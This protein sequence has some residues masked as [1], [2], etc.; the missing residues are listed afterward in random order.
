MAAFERIL[1][2]IP[3][4]DEAFH[5]IRLGDNVVWQVSDL[6]E[7]RAFV[8]PY[9]EQAKRDKRNLIYI[10]FAAHE[11]II[12]D[13]EGVKVYQVKLSHRFETFTIEIHRI[14]EK[15]GR[16]A[17]Y[18]FDC[19]SELQVAWSTDLM[20][21]N[22]FRVTCPFLFQLDTVA[23]FPILRGRHSFQA[24]AKIRETTQLL[25]DVYSDE[26]CLYVHPLKV[27]NR[28][29]P[30]MFLPHAYIPSEGTFKPLTDGVSTS[31]FYT[32]L[33]KK[34]GYKAQHH[35]DSYDRFFDFARLQY[36]RSELS[37]D[38]FQTMCKTMMTRDEKLR[39]MVYTAFTPE[40]LF[41]IRARM[42][43]SGMIGGKACGMLLARKLVER[44]MENAQAVLEPHDSFYI[45]SD[46]FYTYIVSNGFWD[47]RIRQRS[48]KEYFTIAPK[49]QEALRN[50]KFPQDIEEQ[51][52]Q[53][54]EYYGQS[55][56]IVRS[57]SLLEDGFGN[58]F[59]GK[60]ESVF[61]VNQGE[62]EERLQAFEDAVRTVYAST[63]DISALEYRR[64]RGLA[65]RDEQ[66]ALLVQRVSGS[67]YDGFFMPDA[68][69]VGYSYSSYKVCEEM[70]PEEGMLRVV[71]GLGTR[72]VD[73]TNG[74]YPCIIGLSCPEEALKKRAEDRQKYSQHNIDVLDTR[75]GSLSTKTLSVLGMEGKSRLVEHD[76][77][78][79]RMFRERGQNRNIYHISCKGFI[80]NKNLM[81][82]M[83]R[84][85]Q[86][87]QEHYEY[88]VDIEFT[89]NFGEQEDY[90][91]NLLQCRPLQLG[92]NYTCEIS[93]DIPKMRENEVLFHIKSASM[94]HS[95]VEDI[96]HVIFIDP[97][98]YYSFPYYSKPLVARAVGE[99]NRYYKEKGMHILLLTPGRIGT[100][101]PELGVPVVFADICN[102]MGICEISYSKAGYC[103]ELSFGSHMF[104]DLVEAD[105]YYGA[106]YENERTQVWNPKLFGEERNCYSEIMEE[107][108]P[109][110]V[111]LAEIIHVY[112]TRELGLLFYHNAKKEE[113]VCG[114]REK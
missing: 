23:Y 61:C 100:S 39:E 76:Y 12:T 108:S 41:H 80:Q 42:I 81:H 109:Q 5:N 56:I 68:A 19:L 57:S 111:E 101:S 59:A 4:M 7:F 93:E 27:W 33:N 78:L 55:P 49:L 106:I 25:L 28:Y 20:M 16:D 86:I 17:F 63:M 114:V 69:G 26:K 92:K 52:I 102:F 91:V 60:Y 1:S 6:S 95:R 46:V 53:M 64:Q 54:L 47:M 79:E 89:V 37:S 3:Q 21:G 105:I 31:R 90:V 38:T 66:M 18:V 15:E 94:G 103:P 72:A 8:M 85:L 29:S 62:L 104:Q 50:G 14:I 9:V 11:P 45:G 71:M 107:I 113:T 84:I 32:V 97:Q 13:T 98:A 73:R 34:D 77:E 88:P 30:T 43:G 22:F 82:T 35:R 99:L 70:K 44:E 40:D 24:V 2:G 51:F 10:R 83:K 58:A 110:M 36:D 74:D 75:E 96:T 48:E 65:D 67:S 87:L 112:D